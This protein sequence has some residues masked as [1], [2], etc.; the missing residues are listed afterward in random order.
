MLLS[1]LT[2]VVSTFNESARIGRVIENFKPFGRVLIVDNYSEDNTVE[3]ARTHGCDVLMNKNQGWT[4]DEETVTNVKQAVKT[5]WIYWG[6]ADEM[7]EKTSIE[8]MAAVIASEKY[9]VVSILRKN[10]YYGRFCHGAFADRAPRAFRKSAID[11]TGNKIHS[12]GT[13]MVPKERVCILEGKYFIHHFISNTA[14]SYLAVIDR[15]TDVEMHETGRTGGVA[16]I[17][18]AP[19]RMFVKNFLIMGG[20]RG[21]IP[22]FFLVC[23]MVIYRWLAVMKLY[24]AQN[25]VNR[26]QIERSNDKI[27]DRILSQL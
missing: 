20:Y 10:H 19:L 16:R 11:F 12:F 24:E 5:E 1:N 2:F 23:Q 26:N 21:G 7:L 18:I 13:L 17:V 27:R 25:G 22:V 3:I 6:F 4:E 15:Y 9:D 14:K 8:E